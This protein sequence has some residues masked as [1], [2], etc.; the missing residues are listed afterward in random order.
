MKYKAIIEIPKGSDRR[1]HMQSDGS[2]FKDFGPIKERIPVNDGIMPVAYGYIENAINKTE[3]DNVDVIVF[4]NNH[5]DTG[6]SVV[7]EVIGLLRRED[8]D[9]KVVAT[10]ESVSYANIADI[11]EEDMDLILRY[12]GHTHRIKV[13]GNIRAVEYLDECLESA[14]S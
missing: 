14:K 9:H 12:F 4:S 1:I 7:V 5:F 6:D 8:G 3:W 10:D 13:E 2:G 11:L